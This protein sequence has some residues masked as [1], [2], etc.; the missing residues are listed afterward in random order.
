VKRL[1]AKASLQRPYEDQILTPFQLFTCCKSNIKATEFFFFTGEEHT[2]AG[3]LLEKLYQAVK[4]VPG[5]Q[6]FHSFLPASKTVLLTKVL[7]QSKESYAVSLTGETLKQTLTVA[8]AKGY[9]TCE[10]HE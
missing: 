10:Y 9:V 8:D 2:K 1:A 4:P 5:T 6:R 3:K 7:S